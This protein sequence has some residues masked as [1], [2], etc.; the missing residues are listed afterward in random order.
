MMSLLLFT[1]ALAAPPDH[2]AVK[3]ASGCT[4]YAGPSDSGGI[5]PMFADCHWPEVSPQPLQALLGKWD[6]YDQYI[7]AIVSCT[8]LKTEGSRTLV[9]QVQ[10]APAIAQREVVVW[11]EAVPVSDGMRFTWEND[12]SEPLELAKGSVRAPRNAGY[13][14]VTRHPE[15]GARVVH[16]ISYDPGGRVPAWL[17][18]RFSVGGLEGVMTEV[19]ALAVKASAASDH[20]RP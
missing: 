19:R 10:T 14:E 13:W 20:Q 3:E 12:P 9:H 6:A 1:V 8:V 16:A 4:L 11:M 5:A 18:R 7:F 2:T 15:G 17:V